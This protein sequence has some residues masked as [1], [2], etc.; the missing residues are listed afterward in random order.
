MS[1]TQLITSVIT[2]DEAHN[3]PDQ[4]VFILEF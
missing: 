3:L 2:V 1:E 4:V